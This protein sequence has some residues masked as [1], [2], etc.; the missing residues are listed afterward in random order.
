MTATGA[1][2]AIVRATCA[3]LWR[4]IVPSTLAL[5][6]AEW[7]GFI[8]FGGLWAAPVLFL[9]LALIHEV[10]H[11]SAILALGARPVSVEWSPYRAVCIEHSGAGRG[12]NLLCVVAGPVSAFGFGLLCGLSIGHPVVQFSAFVVGLA[13]LTPILHGAY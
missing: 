3:S 9:V 8:S 13:H 12:R 7:S 6:A 11:L 10:G 4:V 5:L 1:L 2:L